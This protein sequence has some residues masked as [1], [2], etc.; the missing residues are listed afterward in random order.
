[1]TEDEKVKVLA[2]WD[3]AMV[4]RKTYDQLSLLEVAFIVSSLRDYFIHRSITDDEGQQKER[5]EANRYLSQT[6]GFTV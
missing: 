4:D 5:M 3:R 2:A 6:F 1:M